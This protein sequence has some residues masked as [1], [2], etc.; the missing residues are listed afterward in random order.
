M[1]GW[2]SCCVVCGL[3]ALGDDPANAINP[4]TTEH[5]DHP[6]LRIVIIPHIISHFMHVLYDNGNVNTATKKDQPT[7]STGRSTL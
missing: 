6:T 5:N 1:V 4:H 7:F 2:S 3:I